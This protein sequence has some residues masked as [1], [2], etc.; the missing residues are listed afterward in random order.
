M[1][2]I[3]ENQSG[4]VV[5]DRQKK[6]VMDG[7]LLLKSLHNSVRSLHEKSFESIGAGIKERIPTA[8]NN[9]DLKLLEEIFR[10]SILPILSG[11]RERTDDDEGSLWADKVFLSI[12]FFF[13]TIRTPEFKVLGQEMKTKFS[14]LENRNLRVPTT[15]V[16]NFYQEMSKVCYKS[17]DDLV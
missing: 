14:K 17:I 15:S 5:D 16:I 1:D 12:F 2:E 3:S 8:S 6:E 7:K 13:S 10:T 9:I 4:E 11:C